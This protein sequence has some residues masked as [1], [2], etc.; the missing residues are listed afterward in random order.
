MGIGFFGLGLGLLVSR[1]L[2]T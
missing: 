2:C 1:L